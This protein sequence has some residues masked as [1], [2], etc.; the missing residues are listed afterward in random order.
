LT[1][2]TRRTKIDDFDGG[3]L[4]VAEKDILRLQITVYN[5]QLGRRQEEQ[6][7]AKLLRKLPRQVEG[8]AAE[9]RVPQQVVQVVR[10]QFKHKT[11]VVP[12]HEVAL[13]SY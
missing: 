4:G 3:A 12:P 7:R 1:K 13:Q 5:G 9:V 11:Q 8:D 2:L 10:E 6:S